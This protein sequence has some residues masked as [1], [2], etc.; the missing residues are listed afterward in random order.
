MAVIFIKFSKIC[1]IVTIQLLFSIECIMDCMFLK[2]SL[3][4]HVG[5]TCGMHLKDKSFSFI[6]STGS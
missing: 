1:A 4:P 2:E 5:T 3:C 6:V